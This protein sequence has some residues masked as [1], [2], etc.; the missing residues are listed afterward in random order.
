MTNLDAVVVGSGPNGL[1]AALT[2]A[3]SGRR[4]RSLR[5]CT[6]GGRWLPHRGADAAGLPARRVLGRPPAGAG[7]AVL[8]ER[9]PGGERGQVAHPDRGFRPPSRRWARRCHLGLGGR[10]GGHPGRRCPDLSPALR[11]LGPGRRQGPAHRAGPA[12]GPAPAPAGH[13]P[14][15]AARA[16]AG[17]P[18]GPVVW[19]RRGEGVAGGCRRTLD[20]PAQHPAHGFLRDAVRGPGPC[21]RLAR[22]RGRQQPRRRLPWWKSS[23][24]SGRSWR[25][26]GG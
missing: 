4:R 1:A 16:I 13:G 9:R 6:V 15:G 7:V 26:A 8:P 24:L 22:R 18:A 21:L 14:P 12:A 10:D 2:I 11:P 17:H 3:R 5:R 19:D 20:A 23:V 25:R